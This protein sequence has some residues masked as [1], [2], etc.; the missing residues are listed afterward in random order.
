LVRIDVRSDIDRVISKFQRVR[1]DQLPFAIA[2]AVT[3]TAIL[4]KK[5]LES[6]MLYAFD[7]PTPYTLGSLYLSPATK[8]VPVAKVWLKDDAGKGTPAA[9][10]LLSEITGGARR[11]KR[12]ENALAARGLLPAGM[13]VMPGSAAQLDAYG[14][15]QRG[16]IVQLLS[17]LGAAES[18]AGFLANRTKASAKRK[19]RNLAE[20]FVGQPGGAPLGIW[21]RVR[22]G[23]GS[24]VKPIAIFTRAP[25]YQ[26]RYRFQD[27]AAQVV[28]EEF[29][30]QFASA[31]AMAIAT[32]R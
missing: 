25:V 31:Y 28:R 21:Q 19:G 13:F 27:I 29:E 2:K 8:V 30:G 5:A 24:A 32:A 4:A 16:Q 14:N 26:V 3:D 12:F 22:F 17:A 1:R 10:F 7:R 11:F 23:Y 15:M 6:E 20:Y 9:K 18:R